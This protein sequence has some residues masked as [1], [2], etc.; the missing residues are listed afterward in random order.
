MM[1]MLGMDVKTITYIQSETEFDRASRRGVWECVLSFLN[2]RRQH[3]LALGEVTEGLHVDRTIERG[4]YDVPLREIRGSA[5]RNREY[6]RS[7]LPRANDRASKE[8]WRTIYTRAVTGAGFPPISLYK[9]GDTYFVEDG[10][11]RV[12]VARYLGWPTIQAF[13]TEFVS[14]GACFCSPNNQLD[15]DNGISAC[16][17]P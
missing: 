12:S 11:H 1:E 2:G 7:F 9:I 10:H 14:S 16:T 5:G 17:R 3:L 15:L 4:L 8:R 13:V 6:T